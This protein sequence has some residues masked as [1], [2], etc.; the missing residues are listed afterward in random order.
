MGEKHTSSYLASLHWLPNIGLILNNYFVSPQFISQN[1]SAPIFTFRLFAFIGQ[2]LLSIACFQLKSKGDPAFLIAAPRP[3]NRLSF[4]FRS[5]PSIDIF[6]PILKEYLGILGNM[7]IIHC[8][9]ETRGPQCGTQPRPSLA[10]NPLQKS[11]LPFFKLCFLCK[12]WK[13]RYM[14]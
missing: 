10:H 6:A 7:I 13:T 3:L 2:S 11:Q 8:L 14:N 4:T 9:A 1:S 12:F 5:S